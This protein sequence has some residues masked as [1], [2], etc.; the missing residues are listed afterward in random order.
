MHPNERN[1]SIKEMPR[2]DLEAAYIEA[3]ELIGDLLLSGQFRNRCEDV[4]AARE[5]LEG[6]HD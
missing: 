4:K 6:Q 2:L 3:V 1:K 5:F